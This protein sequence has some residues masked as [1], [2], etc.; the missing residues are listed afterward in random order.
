MRRP[1]RIL[2]RG[3]GCSAIRAGPVAVLSAPSQKAALIWMN[4][5]T[6]PRCLPRSGLS[7]THHVLSDGTRPGVLIL[8][9][10]EPSPIA[11][12]AAP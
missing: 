1:R 9:I 11:R 10:A 8:P 7:H 12:L 4:T 6:T 3:A 2:L 5:A